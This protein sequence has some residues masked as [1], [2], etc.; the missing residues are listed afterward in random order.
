[1]ANYRT[2]ISFY[3]SNIDTAVRNQDVTFLTTPVDVGISGRNW[4]KHAANIMSRKIHVDTPTPSMPTG[5]DFVSI[6]TVNE[7]P[8]KGFY[9]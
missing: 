6:K 8:R 9:S 2:K 4:V 7:S 3:Y 1:M 5:G